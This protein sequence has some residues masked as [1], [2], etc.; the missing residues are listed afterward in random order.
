MVAPIDVVARTPLHAAAVNGHVDCVEELCLSDPGHVNDKDE[1]GLT[2]LH[3][4]AR[5]GHR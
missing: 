1:R 3:L 4:A 5:E 2:A